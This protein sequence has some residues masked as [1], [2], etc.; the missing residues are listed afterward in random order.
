MRRFMNSF[1]I[2]TAITTIL[3]GAILL[4]LVNGQNII[5]SKRGIDTATG[6]DVS[7]MELRSI[8]VESWDNPAASAAY[9][10][11]VYTDKDT[12]QP[13][14]GQQTYQP[15]AQNAQSLREVKLIAGKPGD[16]KNVDAGTAKVL[17]VKFQFTYPGDNSVTI[18]P[19][20]VPEYEVLRTKSYLDSNNQRKVS[21]IYGVEFPG[22]SKAL[23]V[24]VCGRG[25]E[26]SLEGW[27]EDWKGDTHI[28]QFGSLD[29][30]G[31]RPLT[32]GIPQGVPQ[33]VNSYPQV[34][35][36]VFKQFK[37]RSRPDTSGETV[38][39][40]FDELR[41]LS[42]VFE[43]HF[44]GA[45]ID[46]DDEDCKSK[47]KLDKMLKTKVGKECGNGGGAATSK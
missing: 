12:Q 38:Y 45:S 42:D 9:G 13:Q 19:P 21:K 7:G 33:D 32:V 20:R 25:N 10:W 34:K 39:L 44:D 16:I 40:F 11:E 4:G 47:H 31:W 18:R 6:I 14:A 43:V 15:V 35:T 23:S 30:I 2:T 46:F 36:I 41:V 5:K 37:I 17:G 8:T 24:W 26:Y 27:I 29:F 1:K 28:L 3:G 22:V